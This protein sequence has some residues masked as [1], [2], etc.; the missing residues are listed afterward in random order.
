VNGTRDA[1]VAAL[2]AAGLTYEVKEYPDVNHAFF[3]DTGPNYNAAAAT[4]AYQDVID[5]F[6]EHVA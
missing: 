5:W 6:G 1:A 3:N 2:D 4:Q